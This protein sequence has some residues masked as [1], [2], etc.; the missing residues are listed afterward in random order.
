MNIAM[1]RK[2]PGKKHGKK[3]VRHRFAVAFA[4]LLPM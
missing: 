2:G 4:P 3:L 1:Q